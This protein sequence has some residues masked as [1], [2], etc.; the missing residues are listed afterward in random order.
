M[1]PLGPRSWKGLVLGGKPG[2][3]HRLTAAPDGRLLTPHRV[4]FPDAARGLL[5]AGSQSAV[6]SGFCSAAHREAPGHACPTCPVAPAGP[7]ASPC[8]QKVVAVGQGPQRGGVGPRCWGGAGGGA[9][10]E[11]G[12]AGRPGVAGRSQEAVRG[13]RPL[14]QLPGLGSSPREV[15]GCG[16]GGARS[17]RLAPVWELR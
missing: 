8:R 5:R 1:T 2:P 17:P 11:E 15:E 13:S 14:R 12:R 16:E 6:R 3:L 9:E 7:A 4:L 10:E